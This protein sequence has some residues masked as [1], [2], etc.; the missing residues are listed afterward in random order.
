MRVRR[1]FHTFDFARARAKV[2]GSSATLL[3]AACAH[4][5]PASGGASYPVA[6]GANGAAVAPSSGNAAQSLGAPAPAGA[7]P[8][9]AFLPRQPEIMLDPKEPLRGLPELKVENIGLHIGGGPNDAET[10]A[11]FQRAIAARF[12]AFLE[13]YRKNED[14]EKGGRFGIDLHI[15]RAGG[16]AKLEQ[17]RTAMRGPEF[18]ACVVSV[19]ES[20]EFEKPKLGPT[21][22]SY[23][24]HFTL[25]EGS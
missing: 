25:G 23:S 14:P 20:V 8:N 16:R 1:S 17:P 18:R 19:F 12:P 22:I 11:P 24:L 13:C 7:T 15:P 3:L 4:P 10:K 21:T 2:I 5:A 6:P 9:T